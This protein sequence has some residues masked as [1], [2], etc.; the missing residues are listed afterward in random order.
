MKKS[1][2]L[3]FFGKDLEYLVI[4]NS[5]QYYKHYSNES[6]TTDKWRDTAVQIG[7]KIATEKNL[8]QKL[9]VQNVWDNHFDYKESNLCIKKG[10]WWTPSQSSL[11]VAFCNETSIH[12]FKFMGQPRRHITERH[13]YI[14]TNSSF[15]K[16]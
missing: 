16:H 11:A 3:G 10:C 14:S 15:K 4:T 8:E 2:N 1:N 12:G 9:A 13:D 6:N 5:S 7:N